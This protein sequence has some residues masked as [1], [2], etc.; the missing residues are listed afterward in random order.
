MKAPLPGRRMGG[1][2]ALEL[3][4]ILLV[5][6]MIVPCVITLGNAMRQYVV[7]EK[8]SYQ[9]VRQLAAM[10]RVQMAKRAS[11]LQVEGEVQAQVMAALNAARLD[12][13]ELVID[14]D[15]APSSCGT[16]NLPQRI[17]VMISLT[18]HSSGGDGL[19]GW[20]LGAGGLPLQTVAVLRYEN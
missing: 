20:L 11:Y 2:L 18:V 17:T 19:S 15:C 16:A 7:L 10:P 1:M 5:A 8:A 9:A 6:L 13:S 12:T 3:A 14:V 4:M